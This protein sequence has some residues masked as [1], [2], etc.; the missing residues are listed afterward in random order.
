MKLS[1]LL[2]GKRKG[3][4]AVAAAVWEGGAHALARYAGCFLK[5]VAKQLQQ[6]QQFNYTKE[7]EGKSVL[8]HRRRL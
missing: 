6:Q 1:A 4:G 7:G 8:M 5:T 3:F 2:Q